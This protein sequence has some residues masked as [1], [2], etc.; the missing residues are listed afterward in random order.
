MV[1]VLVNSVE[2]QMEVDTGA[3]VSLI[4]ETS[5]KGL[6]TKTHRPRLKP[7]TRKLHTYTG[8]G[9][10][11]LGSLEVEVAYKAQEKILSL[12]VVAGRGPSL[13]GRDS[14]LS[15]CL[16]W[17]ELNP[18]LNL[19]SLQSIRKTALRSMLDHH[20]QIFEDELGKV[21]GVTAKIFISLKATP[22]FCK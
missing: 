11:V 6:W 2:V 4:S 13:L 22:R 20:A 17:K 15:I 5:Y 14:M 21:K 16:D 10:K 3:S 12:L 19:Y 8:E 18:K 9:L 1:T 7:C